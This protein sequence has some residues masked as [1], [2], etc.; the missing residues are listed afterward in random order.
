MI[1]Y[2]CANAFGVLA[3]HRLLAAVG[4][5]PGFRSSYVIVA[6]SQIGKYLPGNVGHHLGRIGLSK[7]RGLPVPRVIFSMALETGSLVLASGSLAVTWLLLAAHGGAAGIREVPPIWALAVIALAGVSLPV[8]IGWLVVR[9]RARI[10]SALSIAIESRPPRAASLL[11]AF[12]MHILSFLALGLVI[13][14]IFSAVLRQGPW[15]YWYHA[16]LFALAWVAGFITPGAPAGLG[17][18]E[19]ILLAILGP[20]YGSGVALALAVTLRLITLAGDGTFFLT[21]VLARRL[22]W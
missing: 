1:G 18:R 6:L 10:E 5:S 9:W 12:V 8:G 11:L 21:G 7:A 4:G 2:L 17:V 19:A 22:F 3:W 14:L 16:G 13:S 20:Q 15:R